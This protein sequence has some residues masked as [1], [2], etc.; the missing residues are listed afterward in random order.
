[1]CSTWKWE[2]ISFYIWFINTPIHLIDFNS[3]QRR[4]FEWESI[5]FFIKNDK[6]KDI[7]LL[8]TNS[9]NFLF[10]PL[11]TID[12]ILCSGFREIWSAN[13]INKQFVDLDAD[14]QFKTN[15]FVVPMGFS[16]KIF[17]NLDDKDLNF[18]NQIKDINW[19]LS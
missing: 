7:N 4:T 19:I 3:E 18:L 10:I 1:M 2:H 12:R 17:I 5:K 13:Y 8:K 9:G 14:H 6:V 15:G 11:D 16:N